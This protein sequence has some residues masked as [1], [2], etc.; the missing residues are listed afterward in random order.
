MLG[1]SH[2]LFLVKRDQSP[3]HQHQNQMPA[4]SG[5]ELASRVLQHAS[6][7]IYSQEWTPSSCVVVLQIKLDKLETLRL[8]FDS[9][10]R[11]YTDLENKLSGTTKPDLATELQNK[12]STKDSKVQGVP[13]LFSFGQREA[14]M[15]SHPSANIHEGISSAFTKTARSKVCLLGRNNKVH[16]SNPKQPPE[17][18]LIND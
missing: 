17:G 7:C 11:R 12:L 16:G 1:P 6:G 18:L 3:S 2:C 8:D 13:H 10:R 9:S 14:R 15:Q 4:A 5:S